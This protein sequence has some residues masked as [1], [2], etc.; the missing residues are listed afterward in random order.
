VK[1]FHLQENIELSS[2]GDWFCALLC[3]RILRAIKDRL[4]ILDLMK[5]CTYCGAEY[6]DNA[7]V[8]AIDGNCL[9]DPAK[10]VK[11]KAPVVGS[12]TVIHE[13]KIYPEYQWSARDGWKF[14]GMILMFNFLWLL[15]TIAFN[16]YIP[17]YRA[18][19]S[20]PYGTV[21][22]TSVFIA[23]NALTAAY[24][25]RTETLLAFCDATGLNRKP[26]EYA[27]F[28]VA[29][30]ICL[31]IIG[32][33]IYALGWARTYSDRE[34][35]AFHRS[36]ELSR[37]PR[38]GI[39]GGTHQTRLCLSS[40]SRLVPDCGKYGNYRRLYCLGPLEP[41]FPLGL[42]SLQFEC[43]YHRAMLFAREI[44]QHLGLYI[45]P[46]GV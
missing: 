21:I 44:R 40:L 30:A 3:R 22:M 43:A 28:G 15:M 29:F 4:W 32:H 6:S 2:V 26:T 17:G 24:F 38:R 41:V 5:R 25:A 13:H 36:H 8:C 7:A 16:G 46:S 35:S 11:E 14:L 19:H 42:G 12:P 34:L 20:G 37:Y 27:W 45:L 9:D 39:L 18:W 23:M 31:R 1:G 33:V 10:P